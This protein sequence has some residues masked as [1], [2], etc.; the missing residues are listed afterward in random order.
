MPVPSSVPLWYLGEEM[1]S[2]IPGLTFWAAA[3]TFPLVLLLP[4]AAGPPPTPPNPP[5]DPPKPPPPGWATL[6]EELLEPWLSAS[7]VPA[8]TPAASAATTT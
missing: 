3:A 7:T 2:T 5:P 6:G 1:M 4:P 8:P